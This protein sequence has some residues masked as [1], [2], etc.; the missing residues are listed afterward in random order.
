M[1]YKF[2]D[3]TTTLVLDFIR[4]NLPIDLRI[5]FRVSKVYEEFWHEIFNISLKDRKEEED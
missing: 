1:H 4:T 2:N 3:E 5:R